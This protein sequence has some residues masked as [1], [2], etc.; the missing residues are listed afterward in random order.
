MNQEV[1]AGVGAGIAGLILFVAFVTGAF[2]LYLLPTII[3]VMRKKENAG[4]IAI[5]NLLLGW[6]FIGWVI[7]LVWSVSTQMVDVRPAAA[8]TGELSTARLCSHCGKYSAPNARFCA[9]CGGQMAV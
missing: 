3:A 4:A 8:S 1:A 5:V 9:N 7:A 6:T 2:L